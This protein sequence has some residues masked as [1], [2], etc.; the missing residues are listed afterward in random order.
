MLLHAANQNAYQFPQNRDII[1]ESMIDRLKPF[2]PTSY[3]VHESTSRLDLQSST[4]VLSPFYGCFYNFIIQSS[5][6]RPEFDRLILSQALW[7]SIRH[8]YIV[9]HLVTWA[10]FKLIT[11]LANIVRIG[12]V[13]NSILGRG[14]ALAVLKNVSLLYTCV[15]VLW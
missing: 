14:G 10:M 5:D 6:L 2:S 7:K 15:M 4:G 11:V 9:T 12:A 8:A 3:D 13:C 1:L